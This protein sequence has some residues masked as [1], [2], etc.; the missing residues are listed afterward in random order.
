MAAFE[1]KENSGSVFKNDKKEKDSDPDYRGSALI[2]GTEHW[3]S[4]W[5]NESNKGHKYLRLSF[6]PKDAK[7]RKSSRASTD[8]VSDDSLGF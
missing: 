6:Q 8:T 7:G 1:H 4:G 3:V 5:I 2:D